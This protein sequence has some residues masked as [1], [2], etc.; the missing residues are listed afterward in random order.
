[1]T[2]RILPNDDAQDTQDTQDDTFVLD[3]NDD[4]GEPGGD[5]GQ[6]VYARKQY[7][8]AKALEETLAKERAE[9][10]RLAGQLAQA[11]KMRVETRTEPDAPKET[12]A[13][14]QAAYERGEMDV[15]TANAKI[16][17]I[18]LRERD[19]FKKEIVET[20][21]QTNRAQTEIQA[22]KDLVGKYIAKFPALNDSSSDLFQEVQAKFNRLVELGSPG[23]GE[24]SSIT[25]SLAVESVLG[26]LERATK[27][28]TSENDDFDRGN[29]ETPMDIGGG[30]RPADGGGTKP[31][32]ELKGIPKDQ[33]DYWV[34]QGYTK[35]EMARK[36]KYFRDT[37][38]SQM[39]RG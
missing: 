4:Q 21:V 7:R 38:F 33:I 30:S 35:E 29:R 34:S 32:G 22:A 36:A 27:I 31:T 39:R 2:D 23:T 3:D 11:E 5:D 1:M 18:R 20:V 24:K 14:I 8:R 9:K 25:E 19:E 28:K 15:A 16:N 12:E 13:D 37:R 6:S 26:S 17:A 10:E